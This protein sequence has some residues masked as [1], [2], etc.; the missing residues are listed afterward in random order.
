MPARHRV[1]IVCSHPIQYLAPWFV[2]LASEPGLDLTVLY[3][4]L[5]G[6]A[7]AAQDRDFGRSVRW[8]VD[9]L[10]GYRYVELAS[11]ALR[12][13]LDRFFGMVSLDVF[14][15]LRRERFDAVVILGWNYALYP[16]ALA[17]A[18]AAGLPVILRGDTVRYVDA[19]EQDSDVEGLSRGRLVA[20]TWLLRR[21]LGSCA[22]AL[23]VSS[24]NRRLLRHYGVPDDRIFGAPYAVDSSRFCLTESIYSELRRKTRQQF[25]VPDDTPLVLFCGKFSPV[26]AP[27][28]LLG[29][30]ARLRAMGTNA[31][32]VLC[33][34]GVLRSSLETQVQHERIADVHFLG[35]RNQ[36]ELP[37]LYA[38]ADV[39]V[40]PSE[41]EAFAMVV[42]EAMHAGLPVIA[43]TRV[44]CV[45]DL[46]SE[47]RT[48]LTFP[49][50]DAAALV[51]CL[52]TLCGEPD[53]AETR[54][55]LGAAAK[56]RMQTWTYRETTRGLIAALDAVHPVKH[57]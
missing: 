56:Q 18:R 21:Y 45:E 29:A 36:S 5:S 49:S 26:K 28:L 39:L 25:D 22:A 31:A 44:G 10:S 41:S 11:H 23:A 54:K 27:Q 16:M 4:S 51:R 34:D 17:A 12:P 57:R 32:L 43:S 20:K 8:D 35:F 2:A 52:Q 3:A 15:L 37:A 50:G 13:G 40:V 9:L 19:D 47:N 14:R 48:G 55:R 7:H 24:G 42:P 46:V 30:Y 1:A 33:G 53:G 6:Q 38:A